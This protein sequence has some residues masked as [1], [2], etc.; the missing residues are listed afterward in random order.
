MK[1]RILV[2]DDDPDILQFVRM[3]LE[4]EGFEADTADGGIVALET[5][6]SRPPD[7]VLLDVMMPEM[8]GL[9][10]LRRLRNS[11][12]TANVPVI[13]LTA[14]ALAEDRVKGLDLGADDYIT[15]PFDLE[16]LIARVRTVLRRAQQMRDLSPLTGLPGNFRISRELEKRVEIEKPFSVVHADLDNFKA[17]NDHYGFMRGDSVIKF[18]ATTLL[19]A[20]VACGDA[21]AFVGHVGGDDF[22]AVIDP[23]HVEEFCKETVRAYDDGILEFYD[24]AD[25]LQGFIE[26]TDRRGERH[27]FP[28]SSISLGVASNQRRQISSEWEASAIAS[29]MKEYAKRQHGSSYQIDR[30]A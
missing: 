9:T 1:E 11:P 21:E 15:K 26:V 22:V 24:T 30:R 13:I 20:A 29:E 23:D 3:N 7:L 6:K 4:L 2:V 16:E 10:V 28:I 25:A 8:D 19:D 17:F 5:A 27:A 12:A 18:A 14:K